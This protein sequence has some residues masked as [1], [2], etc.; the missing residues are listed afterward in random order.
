[1][2][3]IALQPRDGQAA[4]TRGHNV[5]P[6]Q[7]P[8][9]TGLGFWFIA[10]G[11][12]IPDIFSWPIRWG[13]SASGFRSPTPASGRP[14]RVHRDRETT[15]G[16]GGRFDSSGCRCVSNTAALYDGSRGAI[17]FAVSVWYLALLLNE[18][19]AVQ[20]DAACDGTDPLHRADRAVG[21]GILVDLRY[22]S[23]SIISW[24]LKPL[25]PDTRRTSTSSAT[26]PGH[27]SA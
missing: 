10:A 8:T 12:G 24:S 20:G 22:R 18:K 4:D 19:H 3:D 15:S 14:G 16:C 1:M 23:F 2:A 27:G 21:A 25:G 6:A 11:D 17:K 7:G 5:G 13:P 26:P 9:E